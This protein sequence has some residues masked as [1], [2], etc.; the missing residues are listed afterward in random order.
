MIHVVDSTNP[1]VFAGADLSPPAAPDVATCCAVIL[2]AGGR[3]QIA[4]APGT[5]LLVRRVD[6][7]GCRVVLN[8]AAAARA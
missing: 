8:P 1:D 7:P 3:I 5:N 2:A 4:V 6:V